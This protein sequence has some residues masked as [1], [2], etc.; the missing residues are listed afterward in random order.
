[1]KA[2]EGEMIQCDI[3]PDEADLIKKKLIEYCD[4]LKV[5]IVFTTGGTGMGPRDVTPEATREVSEKIIPGI[6]EIILS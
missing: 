5:D 1:M 6:S 2:I 4:S 3:V